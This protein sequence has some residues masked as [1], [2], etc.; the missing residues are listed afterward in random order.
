MTKADYINLI[1]L[2]NA[3]EDEVRKHIRLYESG[4][5]MMGDSF[6]EAIHGRA[7][8]VGYTEID[9]KTYRLRMDVTIAEI[10]AE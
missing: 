7:S 1:K 6:H 2:N 8:S 10:E 3:L 4:M 5:D 9:G